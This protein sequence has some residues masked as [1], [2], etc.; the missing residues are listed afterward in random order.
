MP[1][2]LTCKDLDGNV[3]YIDQNG[4]LFLNDEHDFKYRAVSRDGFPYYI[5]Q[6]KTLIKNH[7]KSEGLTLL[8][9]IR[10]LAGLESSAY[11]EGSAASGE[12]SRIASDEGSR[13]PILDLNTSIS[14]ARI[15]NTYFVFMESGIE[16]K[17]PFK[18]SI[19]SKKAYSGHNYTR[20][21]FKLG[22]DF[23]NAG[24]GF[25]SSLFSVVSESVNYQFISAEIYETFARKKILPDNY[26]RK[27]LKST[28]KTIIY[29]FRRSGDSS[30]AGFEIFTISGNKGF[31]IQIHYS[32]ADGN[33]EKIQSVIANIS[34]KG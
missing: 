34:F 29:S 16:L 19:L 33:K 24:K 7:R 6:A 3:F 21:S 20:D 27:V 8:K 28:D 26:E 13:Y 17:I 23:G 15:E 30:F 25:Y 10:Y 32:A 18:T 1:G 9:S 31:F 5:E 22:I 2:W 4:K 14:F 11:Q 12:I